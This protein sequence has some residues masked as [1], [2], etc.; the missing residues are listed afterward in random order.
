MCKAGAAA[1]LFRAVTE[2]NGPI[3]V[4]VPFV[5]VVLIADLVAVFVLAV[6]FNPIAGILGYLHSIKGNAL[7]LAGGNGDGSR[8]FHQF[9]TV[10]AVAVCH[11]GTALGPGT[12][13]V[14][15]FGLSL[16]LR[17]RKK[18]KN[19]V[20][21]ISSQGKNHQKGDYSVD[22]ECFSCEV[23]FGSRAELVQLPRLKQGTAEVSFGELTIDL[24]GCQEFTPGCTLNLDC[25]FGELVVLLPSNLR[26][27]PSTSTA[28]GD[29]S[30]VG[31]PEADAAEVILIDADANFGQITLRY[32]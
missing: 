22:G 15:A 14:A 12:V 11:I 17:A 26:V 30:I 10:G 32:I 25:S 1:G 23:C 2:G 28:F 19:P 24:R 8:S 16:L 21:R 6:L 9:F 4:I 3:Q 20:F 31:Q 5:I 18:K 29:F 13:G 27:E 7:D